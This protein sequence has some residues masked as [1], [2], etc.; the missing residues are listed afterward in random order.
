MKTCTRC[1]QTKEDNEFETYRNQ[2]KACRS[3]YC[4]MYYQSKLEE[5]GQKK[6]RKKQK[7][8][9]DVAVQTDREDLKVYIDE[10]FEKLE[11]DIIACFKRLNLSKVKPK[12]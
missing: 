3:E 6:T 7:E 4:K 2:C 9:I 12:K 10:R 1:S 8:K 5:R 11:A